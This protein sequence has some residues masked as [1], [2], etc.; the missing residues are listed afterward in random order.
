[1]L[2]TGLYHDVLFVFTHS[3]K[4]HRALVLPSLRF[5]K[6]FEIK[7]K[8]KKKIIPSTPQSR[9][10]LVDTRIRLAN[11]PYIYLTGYL[12]ICRGR[13]IFMYFIAGVG[14]RL[15]RCMCDGRLVMEM[16]QSK[17][18]VPHSGIPDWLLKTWKQ[19][20]Q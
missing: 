3:Y 2:F 20:D 18:P 17:D 5:K 14:D 9:V 12:H 11:I 6:Y 4:R 1:M 16:Y 7:T 10:L 19:T 15:C 13:Y 8:I